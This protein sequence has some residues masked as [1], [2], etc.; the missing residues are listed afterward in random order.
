MSKLAGIRSISAES[1]KDSRLARLIAPGQKQVRWAGRIAATS[2][3]LW[4][5]QAALVASAV[6]GLVQP[7]TATIPIWIAVVGF[8]VLGGARAFGVAWSGQLAFDGA[9]SCLHTE[10][11]Q[12]IARESGRT[13]ED[14]A[15]Q[16][17]A[18][19]ATLAAEKLAH[20][21]PYLNRYAPARARVMVVPLVILAVALSMSWAVALVL[22]IA[23]PL[24]PVFM[25]LIGIAAKSASER[26]M[27][28]LSDMNVLLLE[29]LSALVDIR[30]LAAQDRTIAQ[31]EQSA[32]RLR[33]R[34]MEVLRIAFLS[35]TVLELFAA[36]GVAMVAVYVGLS[37]LGEVSFGSYGT[38]LSVFQ[39]VFLLLL[40][41]DYF[42]PLRDLAAAWHDKADAE[43][44]AKE[45]AELEEAEQTH[46]IGT[47][48]PAPALRSGQL[49]THALSHQISSARSIVFPDFK[50]APGQILAITGPSGAGK[51]TLLRLLAGLSAPKTGEIRID[52]CPLTHDSADAWRQ[53]LGWMPQTP[54][55]LSGSLRANLTLSHPASQSQ[56]ESALQLAHATQVVRRLPKGL[57][58]R[59]GENGAGLSGGEAR[60]IM[61]ARAALGQPAYVLADEPTA[62]LDDATAQHV[63][64]G[65]EQ[66]RQT[67][68]GLILATHDPV[69]IDWA[70]Q[71]VQIPSGGRP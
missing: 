33:R 45:L 4:L 61:L 55:F 2:S 47:G 37:L 65:L 30:L 42:Q 27:A 52:G 3:L 16:P 50:V 21:T 64:S 29:R 15:R 31:F 48:L 57:Q 10:R 63:I 51:T 67:G 53:S 8:V 66:L 49:S 5:A 18:A 69:L 43:A 11:K 44:V 1:A 17:A 38:P 59:L 9:Q 60:R 34:T 7:E 26:Q 12:L 25:A 70:D 40:A 14:P 56:I 28:E 71:V 22:L 23:G 41:P 19:T 39:G 32:E 13:A 58:T 54:H 24:I 6:S 68:C 36:I 62:D 46:F 20:L 35:S